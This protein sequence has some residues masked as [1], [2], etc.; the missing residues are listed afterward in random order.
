MS[1]TLLDLNGGTETGEIQLLEDFEAQEYET[2]M[3]ARVADTT[4]AMENRLP[5]IWEAIRGGRI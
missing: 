2:Q 5:N 3:A 4:S 1:N